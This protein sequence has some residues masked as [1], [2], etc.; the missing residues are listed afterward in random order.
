VNTRI[1]ILVL[2]GAI[3][4]GGALALTVAEIGQLTNQ[5]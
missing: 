2:L 1:G 3:I 4:A 5:S